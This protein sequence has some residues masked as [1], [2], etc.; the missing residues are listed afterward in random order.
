MFTKTKKLVTLVLLLSSMLYAVVPPKAKIG[1]SP[2][3]FELLYDNKRKTNVITLI[4]YSNKKITAEIS[5]SNWTLENG[6]I[7]NIAPTPQS[8]D[9]W[10]LI[11]P[12]RFTIKPNDTKT[13]RFAI[14]PRTKPTSGEHRAMIWIDEILP[15]GDSEG[16]RFKFQLGVPVYLNVPPTYAKGLLNQITTTVGK[17][18]IDVTLA[19]QNRGNVHDRLTGSISLWKASSNISKA[20]RDN[21]VKKDLKNKALISTITLPAGPVLPKLK[22]KDILSIPKP[23]RK[24]K[25]L[26]YLKGHFKNGKEIVKEKYIYIK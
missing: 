15:E 5:L 17:E 25:Y 24:G 2:S 16:I 26:L 18:S 19:L 3:R 14:R 13:I 22:A 12:V 11:T 8:L 23:K 6:Q 1:V 9:Q 4:N 7:K 21:I 20:Q 10:I